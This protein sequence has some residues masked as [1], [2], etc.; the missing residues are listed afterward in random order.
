MGGGGGEGGHF[1][2]EA[3]PGCK[4]AKLQ[5]VAAI[6]QIHHL[7][8]RSTCLRLSKRDANCPQIL[9]CQAPSQLCLT[10]S[11]TVMCSPA[12]HPKHNAARC[13]GCD[14]SSKRVLFLR[15][16]HEHPPSKCVVSSEPEHRQTSGSLPWPHASHRGPFTKLSTHPGGVTS[17]FQGWKPG[18]SITLLT[19]AKWL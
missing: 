4:E 3:K 15:A 14:F 13:Q 10:P 5:T 16:L 8:G 17:H 12:S 6:R 9:A 2:P 18:S 7:S 1:L 11:G 19:F